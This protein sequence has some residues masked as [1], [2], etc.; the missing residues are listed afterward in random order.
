MVHNYLGP[1]DSI[2][3]FYGNGYD[4]CGPLKYALLTQEGNEFSNQFFWKDIKYYPNTRDTFKFVLNSWERGL[5]V[6]LNFTLRIEL[7]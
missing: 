6:H 5:N 1:T 2:S 7:E 4:K 3:S